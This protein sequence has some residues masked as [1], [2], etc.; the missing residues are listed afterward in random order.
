[1]PSYLITLSIG[2]VQSLID[3][4]RRTRDLWCGSWLLSE[5]S[6]AAARSLHEAQPGCLV[7]PSVANPEQDLRPVSKP[8]DQANMANILR[9]SVDLP[10]GG[11][12]Q[13]LCAEAQAAARARL[14]DI[15]RQ[16]REGVS[17]ALR[18][19]LWD[20]QLSDLLEMQAAWVE[21]ER[22]DNSPMESVYANA[23]KALSQMLAARKSTR[24]F[25]QVYPLAQP[26]LPK[27]SL[28]GAA[29]TVLMPDVQS[30]RRAR[31]ELGLSLGEQLDALGVIKRRAG[32]VEQF[33][34]WSRIAV[35]P[36]IQQLH[37][38]QP[39]LL[40]E[41]RQLYEPLVDLELATRIRGNRDTYRDF[42]YD[43][44]LLFD[45]RLQAAL[46]GQDVGIGGNKERDALQTLQRQLRKVT[47]HVG[48]PVPYAAIL[49]AD[50]DHM[51]ALLQK[52]R[53]LADSRRISEHLHRFAST[54]GET[55]RTHRGHAIYA[56][57]DD[58]LALVPLPQAVSCAQALAQDFTDIMTEVAREIGVSTD[59]YPTL[60]VGLGIGHI[61]EP[62]GQLRERAARAEHRAKHLEGQRSRNALSIILG[63]RS[64]GELAW[65]AQWSQSD[66][67]RALQEFGEAYLAGQ[68]S[69]RV[70]YDLRAIDRR[71]RAL[72]RLEKESNGDTK[73]SR[74]MQ[75]AEVTRMLERARRQGG[76][77]PLQGG[78]RER[79]QEEVQRQ[80]LG[81]LADTLIL[82]RW[83][84]ARNAA[85]LGDLY[86]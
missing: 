73:E 23:S 62:L 81:D 78:M 29:E 40:A 14:L 48:A 47:R 36:W 83:L 12:V 8:G 63:I 6:R 74:G 33:T 22:A 20:T 1:M 17:I 80:S 76:S 10:D 25:V 68:L 65:R 86:R 41:L 2:P 31:R 9:A 70:A 13:R 35:D 82:A 64:G 56:G 58:V 21:L 37:Q 19:E 3:A 66:K 26:G 60:S 34:A 53:T 79:I 52:A 45:F 71:F 51:G 59:A 27:S 44:Q 43:G 46:A 39:E 67:F 7:F 30:D 50:G 54:V 72:S 4:A 77:E 11:S 16:V 18:D 55:V 5:V 57:G 38:S 85:D 15:G 24:D 49:K 32:D 28:D 61:M 42:P 75:M 69:S 84:A